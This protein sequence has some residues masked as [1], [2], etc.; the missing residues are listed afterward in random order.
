M[1]SACRPSIWSAEIHLRFGFS[2]FPHPISNLPESRVCLIVGVCRRSLQLR[3]LR[4]SVVPAFSLGCGISH[5]VLLCSRR[6]SCSQI[7][8]WLNEPREIAGVVRRNPRFRIELCVSTISLPSPV[9]SLSTS[10]GSQ[11]VAF[12]A[13]REDSR[14]RAHHPA[15]SNGG[16]WNAVFRGRLP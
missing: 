4:V 11:K 7:S 10:I 16:S 14:S 2:V 6:S 5:V 12:I 15:T 8:N 1:K 13:P 3:F 9:R